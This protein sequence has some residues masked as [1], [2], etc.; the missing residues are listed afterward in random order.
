MAEFLSIIFWTGGEAMRVNW[1]RQLTVALAAGGL[2]VDAT[3]DTRSVL[4]RLDEL[5]HEVVERGPEAEL[6]GE[7]VFT[8]RDRFLPGKVALGFGWLLWSEDQ[9]DEGQIFAERL[10]RYRTLLKWTKAAP[11]HTWGIYHSLSA[12]NQLRGAGLLEEAVPLAILEQMRA[13]LDWRGFVDAQTYELKRLPANYYG[14]AFS[15]ARLRAAFGWDDPAHA[16]ALLARMVAHYA[17]HAGD[18][19]FS[20]EATD[21]E[22]R[23]DRYSVLLA[24]EMAQRF[25]ET[26]TPLDDR[27]RYWLERSAGFVLLNLNAGGHG[28]QFGRSVGPYGDTAFL[29]VLSAAAYYGLLDE[30]EEAMAYAFSQRVLRKYLDFWFDEGM[31]SVN[32]WEHGRTTDGYRGKHRLLGEN[33]S[34]SHHLLYTGEIWRDLGYE[35]AGVSDEEFHRWLEALPRHSLT[36]FTDGEWARLNLA[37]RDGLDRFGLWLS[38]GGPYHDTNPYSPI[39]VA[40]DVVQTSPGET[41]PQLVPRLHLSDGEELA[42]LVFMQDADF[43]ADGDKGVLRWE[44]PVMNRI[45][46]SRPKADERASVSVEYRFSP[47]VIERHDTF[48]LLEPGA[49][50]HIEVQF[51]SFSTDPV[52]RDT[53]VEFSEG[54]VRGFEVFGV[55]SCELADVSDDPRYRTP[56]GPKATRI[57]CERAIDDPDQGTVELGW[58]LSYDP[59]D[60]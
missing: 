29:E 54:R 31:G 55:D 7:P 41:W 9:P 38:N 36:R 59:A 24:G 12:L 1:L 13:D 21:G 18:S 49:V 11:N 48:T 4:D 8:G 30:T 39:P 50:E 6:G 37:V 16:D 47:G 26:G 60:R 23:F 10:E 35:G 20:D 43:A 2:A 17:E 22:G 46:T 51:A 57:R 40:W 53:R 52:L 15:I 28:F 14:V 27:V 25:R 32:L 42:P 45:G 19:G 5:L 3:A 44:H 58:R 56:Q 33:L 34:L